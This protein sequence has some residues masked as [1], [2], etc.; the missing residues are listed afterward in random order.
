MKIKLK[1]TLITNRP[2]YWGVIKNDKYRGMFFMLCLND[3][4]NTM[5]VV[6]VL[7]FHSKVKGARLECTKLSNSKYITC[8]LLLPNH[9]PMA[10]MA[11]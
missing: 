2:Y 10:G 7:G 6:S 8:M 4:A 3:S 1:K 11:N 9:E 5:K